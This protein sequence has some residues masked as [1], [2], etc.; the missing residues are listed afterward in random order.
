MSQRQKLKTYF[1]SLIKFK[2]SWEHSMTCTHIFSLFN[3]FTLQPIDLKK[4]SM[5]CFWHVPFSAFKCLSKFSC[6]KNTSW[7]CEH[8]SLFIFF[9]KKWL[10]WCEANWARVPVNSHVSSPAP[11]LPKRRS[12]FF[13]ENLSGIL[14]FIQLNKSF[15]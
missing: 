5:G 3:P 9:A 13:C 11:H 4:Q 8:L 2:W 7:Q 10:L 6:E 12:I 15:F 1:Y 14:Y